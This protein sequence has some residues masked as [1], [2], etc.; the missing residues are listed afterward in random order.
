MQQTL[1]NEQLEE[2]KPLQIQ[3]LIDLGKTEEEAKAINAKLGKF[4]T[5]ALY[6]HLTGKDA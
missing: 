5:P 1:T 3:S 2:I 4:A 6:K